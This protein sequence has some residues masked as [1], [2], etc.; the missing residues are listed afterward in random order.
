MLHDYIL[1]PTQ[2]AH[3]LGVS[4]PTIWRMEKKGLLPPRKKIGLRSIG[5]LNSEIDAWLQNSGTK[6]EE[7]IT[8]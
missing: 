2:L 1:R 5:W 4:Q 8:K 3:K 6:G 7:Q